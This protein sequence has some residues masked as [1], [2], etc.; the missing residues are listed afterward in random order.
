MKT[1]ILLALFTSVTAAFG[2]G[3]ISFDNFVDPSSFIPI[4]GP[5]PSNPSLSLSGQSSMGVPP[6]TTVYGG[7]LLQGT[8]YV[9]ALYGGPSTVTDPAA[10]IFLTS[11]TFYTS[12]GNSFP[13]GVLKEIA[14]V[15]VP[16]VPSGA[17]AKFE[18]RVWDSLSGVDFD[19]ATVRGRTGLIPSGQL[20]PS[21]GPA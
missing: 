14:D 5:D 21:I 1:P 18:I 15:P 16:G 13:A 11:T 4:Y 7:P 6:G 9:A 12:L 17:P 20:G 8:R 19:S 2:Q 10:L 3:L